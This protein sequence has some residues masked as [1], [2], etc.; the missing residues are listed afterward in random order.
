MRKDRPRHSGSM[1]FLAVWRYDLLWPSYIWEQRLLILISRIEIS[2]SIIK[3]HCILLLLLDLYSY[4]SNDRC[5]HSLCLISSTVLKNVLLD[6]NLLLECNGNF[7]LTIIHVYFVDIWK[8]LFLISLT[9]AA[10]SD[11]RWETIIVNNNLYDLWGMLLDQQTPM[12]K[13]PMMIDVDQ[14]IKIK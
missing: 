13:Q 1:L 10:I 3:T 2:M 4:I 12:M 5:I 7:D 6:Y 9:R 11:I 8:R 14:E